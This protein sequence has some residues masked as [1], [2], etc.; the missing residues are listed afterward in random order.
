MSINEN[1]GNIVESNKDAACE[2]RNMGVE[3]ASICGMGTDGPLG[4]PDV[5]TMPEQQSEASGSVEGNSGVCPCNT[6]HIIDNTSD[7][8]L[9]LINQGIPEGRVL[10][11]GIDSLTLS[12]YCEWIKDKENIE[13]KVF[14]EQ[15]KD[16]KQKAIASG[17]IT[18]GAIREMY[19]DGAWN[20]TIQR[21]GIRGYN[22]VINGEENDFTL[23]VYE[24]RKAGNRPRVVI[25][26]RSQYLHAVGHEKAI[27]K[28]LG[29][30]RDTGAR[31]KINGVLV[32]R[33]DLYCDYL[34]KGRNI[35]SYTRNSIVSKA[36][37]DRNMHEKGE[38]ETL[39][40]GPRGGDIQLRIYDKQKQ[41]KKLG[42]EGSLDSE[43]N[44]SL[45]EEAY[46]I[47]RFEYQL[48]REALKKLGIDK[49]DDITGNIAGL[50]GYLTQE[51]SE[52]LE[53]DDT[54]KDRRVVKKYWKEE[55]H[56]AFVQRE[57]SPVI[58]KQVRLKIVVTNPWASAKE[59]YKCLKRFHA[60]CIVTATIMPEI[61]CLQ[62]VIETLVKFLVWMPGVENYEAE[63]RQ[64]VQN[65]RNRKEKDKL[66]ILKKAS[67]VIDISEGNLENNLEIEGSQISDAIKKKKV[68]DQEQVN[69]KVS[70]STLNH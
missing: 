29:V 58:E 31:I 7:N 66:K 50:W 43:W 40:V 20:F 60:E 3:Q 65:I 47:F 69:E 6:P 22:L 18:T 49:P 14:P 59:V 28:A 42:E 64:E 32:S 61:I 51:W 53:K 2:W 17:E 5:H 52:D 68:I 39:Y 27:K 35:D 34:D 57:D 1:Q 21:K 10:R 67:R 62:T 45:E 46:N 55:I 16:L 8:S 70:S 13:E 24:G 26:I 63:V 11:A 15:L 9:K 54:H 25:E 19:G 36:G 4:L 38:L 30:L 56:Q 12:I 44:L 48:K 33:M 41:L 37:P 23:Q